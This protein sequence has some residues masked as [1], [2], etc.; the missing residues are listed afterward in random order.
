MILPI[1]Y[2]V[3]DIKEIDLVIN[4]ETAPNHIS[5]FRK[6]SPF[7]TYVFDSLIESAHNHVCSWDCDCDLDMDDEDNEEY[8][9]SDINFVLNKFKMGTYPKKDIDDMV[10]FLKYIK[11]HLN[12][13]YTFKLK[14]Q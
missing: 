10:L 4:D 3:N 12:S 7:L 9:K 5:I 1:V 8:S 13:N 11:I 14:I 6:G 2:I